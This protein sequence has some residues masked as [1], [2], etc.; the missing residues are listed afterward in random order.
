M[1]ATLEQILRLFG[2]L[3]LRVHA[4]LELRTAQFSFL[5]ED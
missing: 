4:R 5:S 3:W 2:R 1:T